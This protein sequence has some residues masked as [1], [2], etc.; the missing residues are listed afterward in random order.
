MC[1]TGE[2][3][4]EPAV[5]ALNDEIAHL[6]ILVARLEAQIAAPSSFPR[7]KFGEPRAAVAPGEEEP[8]DDEVADGHRRVD[9]IVAAAPQA[10]QDRMRRFARSIVTDGEVARKERRPRTASQNLRVVG[11][12]VVPPGGFLSCVCVGIPDW[13]CSGVLVAPQVVLTA[14]HCGH[15]IDRIMVGG[16][17]V[18]P[19]LSADARVI[20]VSKAVVH[21]HYIASP[22]SCNDINVLILK[23]PALVPPA[24]L[25]TS[26]ET[27]AAQTFE[28][29]GFGYND[30]SKPLGF[31][32]KRRA[33]IPG[34]AVMAAADE[35]LG[36][37]P[38]VLGFHPDYEFVCGRKFLGIDSCNGDSGGPIYISVDG[39]F[40]LAGLTSRAT[41]TANEQCGDG[42]IYVM[43]Q[44][45]LDWINEVA[46]CAG[47]QPLPKGQIV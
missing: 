3:E 38:K 4:A 26:E 2:F 17:K 37:L 16:T 23:S 24:R 19:Q 7:P 12:D 18:L 22:E 11:G 8:E 41:S 13:G 15:A 27:L 32:T 39:S 34:E 47:V 46:A 10:L 42:G 1:G 45:F 31:G 20:E 28:V 36:K 33:T 21:P 40:K 9:E 43:P 25:A 6:N 29:V 44:R 5:R 14:A 30:P 35:D